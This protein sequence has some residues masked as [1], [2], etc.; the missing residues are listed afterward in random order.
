MSIR[1]FLH[2]DPNFI[3]DVC[4]RK[5]KRHEIVLA[6]GQGTEPVI[7]S[8][9]DGCA[10]PLHPLNFPPPVIFDGRPVPNA[11]PDSKDVYLNIS[12]S[13]YMSWGHLV[14]ASC[15]GLFNNPNTDMNLN[16]QW[17]WGNFKKS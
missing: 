5:R 9:I 14:D 11:R 16:G 4:G 13:S 17:T 8:C 15:W 10:D 7:I 3:C 6:F 1:K 12:Y 2:R